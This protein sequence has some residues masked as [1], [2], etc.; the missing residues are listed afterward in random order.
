MDCAEEIAILR[1]E[2][3][4]LVGGEQHLAFDLLHAKL[5][6]ATAQVSA[7]AI[8]RAIARTGMQAE[9]WP[10]E[11]Q[12]IGPINRRRL[13]T[14]LTAASGVLTAAGL[15]IHAWLAGG[16]GD[17][18]GSGGLTL[19]DGVPLP[20]KAAYSLAVI[21]GGWFIVP[22]AFFALRRMRP[23]MNLLMT[24]AVLGA[25]AIGEWFEGATVVFLFALSN[26]LEGWS[27]GRARRAVEELMDL[28]PTTARVKQGGEEREVHAKAVEV[29]AFF[30]VRPGEKI[31]LDGTVL[32]GHSEVNQAPITGE[33]VPVPRAPGDD[34][35]AG[36]LNGSGAL[37]VRSTR[38]AG[39]T[40]LAKMIRL[41]DAARSRRAPSEQWVERFARVY[42]PTVM[43]LALLVF[44]VPP[45]A[46][47]LSWETWFYRALVLLVIACPCAL[48][49]S[50]P[51]SVV[52]ALAAAARNGVLIKA[53]AYVEA[54][55]RLRTIAFDKTGTLTRGESSVV[56]LVPLGEYDETALLERAASLEARSDHPLARAIQRYAD[57]CG[58]AV[59]PAAGV[60]S[61]PGKGLAGNIEKK[62]FWLGSHRYLEE[63]GQETPEVH[64]RL[65]AMSR[66]G[67]TVIVVGN[68][69]HVCGLIAVSD[70]LRPEA[71]EAL[72]ELRQLG[73]DHQIMLTGDNQGTARAIARELGLDDVRAD[74]LPADKLEAIER[75]ALDAGQVAMVG[76]GV[77]D[78]PAMGRATLGIAMG[79]AG[80]DA[81]IESAD[82]ALMSDDLRKLPWIVRHSRR[83]LRVIH[84]NIV[85]VLGV[86]LL[87]LGLATMGVA[88]LWMAIAADMG[89]SL[90]VI[91]NGLRLLR[92]R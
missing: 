61:I 25:V 75:L 17:A 6:V 89:A 18:L 70:R 62:L 14:W 57:A 37:E 58:V 85:F 87:V 12:R 28:A 39:E 1:K 35:L 71:R 92:G 73:I 72:A 33:S 38:P 86:K 90:L 80:S 52:A 68:E 67:R 13:Q 54:P 55:G 40:T 77:N 45:L 51:I 50:T 30:V 3:G 66:A 47:V 15:A 44:V 63:R 19:T 36:T 10:S 20:A 49:I 2:L 42:T 83:T 56:A 11:A 60:R 27:I 79:S 22:K 5:T 16:L 41:V 84:Q 81:A 31:P 8:G 26:A 82:I 69:E 91:A 48:V 65:E 24:V 43:L 4:P 23:D 46:L 53:G 88:T 21:A 9:P 76:D 78:A 32:A 7:E 29:G 59:R 74:L 34:V 64:D